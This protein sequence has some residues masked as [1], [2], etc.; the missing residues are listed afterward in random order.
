MEQKGKLAIVK[1]ISGDGEAGGATRASE[2]AESSG[3]A[4]IRGHQEVDP[5]PEEREGQQTGSGSGDMEQGL[6]SGSLKKP[7]F[8][9]CLEPDI[10]KV[11]EKVLFEGYNIDCGGY[12]QFQ[13][14]ELS[15]EEY[16]LYIIRP[17][18]YQ[19]L[20][21]Q[22]L[23]GELS[24]EEQERQQRALQDKAVKDAAIGQALQMQYKI[25]M[26]RTRTPEL[27]QYYT[28]HPDEGFVFTHSELKVIMRT[29]QERKKGVKHVPLTNQDIWNL[30]DLLLIN[31]YISKVET[32]AGKN[33]TKERVQYQLTISSADHAALAKRQVAH[34][35]VQLQ[36]QQEEL[37]QW[38]A[39]AAQLEQEAEADAAKQK[40]VQESTADTV[41]T[42]P[43][44]Q[45]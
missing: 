21:Q 41:A 10:I 35:R 8:L 36:Q 38:E 17:Q 2:N 12:N 9:G 5:T 3:T 16:I 23:F 19:G 1:S 34:K 25:G 44:C 32:D 26:F 29:M 31:G 37:K 20:Y 11:I 7:I 45:S 18:V 27:K 40:Q 15:K 22:Y 43:E 14:P 13:D 33:L 24:K 28:E 30:M 39:R 6:V 42:I 4:Q